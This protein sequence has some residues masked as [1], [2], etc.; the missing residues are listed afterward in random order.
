LKQ[1][2]VENIAVGCVDLRIIL[3]VA[4]FG[5]EARE[6]LPEKMLSQMREVSSHSPVGLN[7]PIAITLATLAAVADTVLGQCSLVI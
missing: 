7:N 5:I 2:G 4:T 6:V 1:H 3:Y